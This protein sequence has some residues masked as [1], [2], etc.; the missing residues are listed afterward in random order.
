MNIDELASQLRE[1][2]GKR[3]RI[4]SSVVCNNRWE[5]LNNVTVTDGTIW[6]H[7][8]DGT[9]WAVIEQGLQVDVEPTFGTFDTSTGPD[10]M[11]AIGA[12]LANYGLTPRQSR[13]LCHCHTCTQARDKKQQATKDTLRED[14][15]IQSS[16]PSSGE[17]KDTLFPDF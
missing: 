8:S 14:R 9:S 2:I 16:E 1:Y 7:G 15:R 4:S 11:R 13:E 5:L 12:V 10:Q 17:S 6:C 3:V